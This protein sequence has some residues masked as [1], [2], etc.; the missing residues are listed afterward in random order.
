MDTLPLS[1]LFTSVDT[2]NAVKPVV[3]KADDAKVPATKA[4]NFLLKAFLVSLTS[5]GFNLPSFI[6]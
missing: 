5:I 3:T 1:P 2:T 6:F 4:I